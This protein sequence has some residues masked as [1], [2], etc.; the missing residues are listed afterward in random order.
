M[1]TF[2][3]KKSCDE[4]LVQKPE[5]NDDTP[6]HFTFRDQNLMDDSATV[7]LSK[8]SYELYE[9]N[10]ECKENETGKKF[11]IDSLIVHEETAEIN[12]AG[13]NDEE[14]ENKEKQEPVKLYSEIDGR[15]LVGEMCG[16]FKQK[17]YLAKQS[18]G[19]YRSNIIADNFDFD[20]LQCFAFS[21]R[22]E[23][24]LTEAAS[25]ASHID[26]VYT[27]RARHGNTDRPSQNRQPVRSLCI[28]IVYGGVKDSLDNVRY[29]NLTNI[30]KTFFV[31]F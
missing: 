14:S 16:G 12:L 11:P 29:G 19:R 17:A 26:A 21:K 31:E 18:K 27:I 6:T 10:G 1:G 9:F 22:G 3:N 15:I 28:P 20:E 7:S 23:I 30:A 4:I 2:N 25:A 13:V 5:H 24:A 8:N